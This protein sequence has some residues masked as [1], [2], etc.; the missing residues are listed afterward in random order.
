MKHIVK[1]LVLVVLVVL[2]ATS[3][4]TL[5]AFFPGVEKPASADKSMLIV[6]VG[7]GVPGDSEALI[8]TNFTGWAPWVVDSRGE[9]VQFKPFD[10][11]SRLD[12]FFYAE[13][14]DA[15]EYT[16]KGFFHVY[17]DYGKL[18]DSDTPS[19]GPY[20]NYPYHV[21]QKFPLDNE[22]TVDLKKAEIAT[23]GRY[24]IEYEWKEGASGSSRPLESAEIEFLG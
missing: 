17:T 11:E 13:N 19:Y 9:I 12:S 5:D 20:Q 24:F 21:R 18:K 3:C 15:G 6:E 8:N 7:K 10:T 2:V 1:G 23:F 14:L 16:L 22:V 4:M